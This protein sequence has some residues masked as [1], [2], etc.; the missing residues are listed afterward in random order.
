MAYRSYTI[1]NTAAVIRNMREQLAAYESD[2]AIAAMKKR[3][4]KVVDAVQ[5][6]EKQAWQGWHNALEINR[7]LKEQNSILQ[8]ECSGYKKELLA[9]GRQMKDLKADLASSR[10]HGEK[11]FAEKQELEAELCDR[12]VKIRALEDELSRLKAVIDHDGTTSGISTSKTATGK[13]KVIPN[14]RIK[15]GRKRGGQAGHE[16]KSME[17]FENDE[18]TD[19]EDHSLDKCPEC[20]G[21]LEKLEKVIVKDEYDYEIRYVKKQHRFIEYRCKRCGKTVHARIP[22]HLKEKIQYGPNIEAMILALL[23]IGF[24]STGRA[25]EII[26]GFLKGGRI[27]SLGLVGKVQKKGARLLK[28]F[29]QD[30]RDYCLKQ[31]ILYWDD[32]V[33]FINTAR[34]CF[35]FYGNE[36]VA[37]YKAHLAKNAEGI[38]EDGILANLG[39]NTYL[40]HDHV[41]LNY[42]KEYLFNNLECDQHLERDLQRTANDS[43]HSWAGELKELISGMIHKRNELAEKGVKSFSDAETNEFEEKLVQ[44]TARGRT[45]CQA[46]K[47]RY[48]YTDEK[49]LLNR[50]YEYQENY[51]MWMSD[52]SLPVTNN[53]SERS[54]RMTKTK[55][56][57][58]GQFE[59]EETTKEFALVRTYLETCRRNGKNELK[60]L[61][62]LMEET[63]Y[64]LQELITD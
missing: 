36:K 17:P 37:L 18:I 7:K 22:D 3:C 24:V 43:G 31:R 40:M 34:G 32:T 63:P 30:V 6:R 53:L 52:F 5:R 14:T 46:D 47:G 35:R 59:K 11:L 21:E 39:L 19:T 58:S 1:N 49:A 45:E 20:G 42:R 61:Q 44:L 33:V 23:D 4:D 16:K 12:D 54:L 56:K 38:E 25:R 13:K 48:F 26:G 8:K 28:Q 27:P 9:A 64:T 62:R 10:R 51:F 57:V 60:A 55:L 2:D 15:T 29:E 41:K 50:I